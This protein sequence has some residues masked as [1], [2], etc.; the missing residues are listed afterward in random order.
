MQNKEQTEV[1]TIYGNWDVRHK[2]TFYGRSKYE[3][4][5]LLIDW[6]MGQIAAIRADK[7]HEYDEITPCMILDY[8]HVSHIQ[9]GIIWLDLHIRDGAPGGIIWRTG[10][11]HGKTKEYDAQGDRE[12]AAVFASC[13]LQ[14]GEW[15]ALPIPVE[16]VPEWLEPTAVA[17]PEPEPEPYQ[18]YKVLDI[19]RQLRYAIY[20]PSPELETSYFTA[21][22]YEH[23][24]LAF[25]VSEEEAVNKLQNIVATAIQNL[26]SLSEWPNIPGLKIEPEPEKTDE[27]KPILA[28]LPRTGR[29][30]L[31]FPPSPPYTDYYTAVHTHLGVAAGSP[32]FGAALVDLEAMIG[33]E[34]GHFQTDDPQ[35]T[36]AI[37]DGFQD[38]PDPVDET[39]EKLAT[40]L[41]QEVGE[42]PPR[43]VYYVYIGERTAPNS[44]KRTFV[45][46]KIGKGQ[47]NSNPMGDDSRNRRY[48][49]GEENI[50]PD[51][52]IGDVCRFILTNGSD[53]IKAKD[54]Q[55]VG[56]WLNSEDVQM[57]KQ[58]EEIVGR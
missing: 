26:D 9:S 15:E 18:P 16:D 5:N 23:H 38:A 53:D 47:N 41:A 57:W 45:W 46:V 11:Q 36:A 19:V 7:F 25:G 21:V 34:A 3:A 17:S 13:A 1:L 52:R 35:L 31:V 32:S 2:L 39:A 42:K 27:N 54:S 43:E 4:M 28:Q 37:A 56:Y 12:L 40:A 14:L 6:I 20:P 51:V 30:V 55:I 48:V 29:T 44:H 50:R 8:P 33:G 58:R 24:L 22:C 49:Y 10:G